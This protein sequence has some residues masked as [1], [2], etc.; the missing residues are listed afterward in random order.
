MRFRLPF[1]GGRK[2]ANIPSVDQDTG[3]VPKLED[4]PHRPIVTY[5]AGDNTSLEI[6]REQVSRQIASPEEVDIIVSKVDAA[7]AEKAKRTEA[8]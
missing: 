5:Y 4:D 6:V 8:T 2:E 3:G 7:R 1:S